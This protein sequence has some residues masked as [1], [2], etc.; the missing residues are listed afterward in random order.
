MKEIYNSTMTTI[1]LWAWHLTFIKYK[2][3]NLFS[4]YEATCS[5]DVPCRSIYDIF[6]LRYK[7]TLSNLIHTYPQCK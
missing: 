7:F 2:T 5:G 6:E 4:F 3:V 1:Q